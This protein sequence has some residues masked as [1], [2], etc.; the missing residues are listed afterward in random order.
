MVEH[1]QR[2]QKSLQITDRDVRCVTLAGLLHDLGHG[3]FSHVWDGHFIPLA[4]YAHVSSRY[5]AVTYVL[6]SPGSKWVHEDG[7]KMMIKHL[8]KANDIPIADED[9][10]FI[11]DLVK[12][13]PKE[14]R[15]A[16][17]TTSVNLANTYYLAARNAFSSRSSLTSGTELTLTS[18]YVVTDTVICLI[19]SQV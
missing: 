4:R 16:P 18:K 5:V 17:S 1:L 10:R 12:G 8:F 13:E 15:C 9:L 6:C 11:V 7:S 2:S 3:P 14:S 19:T